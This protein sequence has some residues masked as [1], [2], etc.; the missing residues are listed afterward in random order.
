MFSPAK[1][2]SSTLGVKLALVE[3]AVDLVRGQSSLW[4]VFAA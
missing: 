4:E 1:S 3:P 2:Q